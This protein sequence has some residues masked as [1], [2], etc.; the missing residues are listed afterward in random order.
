M[1]TSAFR[2]RR[3]TT[4]MR[5][6]HP[7]G[8]FLLLSCLVALFAGIVFVPGL[9]GAFVFDDIPNIVNN[10][11]V[12]LTRLDAEALHEVAFSPQLSGS[13]RVLPTLSFALDYWRGEGADAATFRIT[14]IV[15]HALTAFVLAWFFRSLLLA[16]GVSAERVRWAAP[17]L[18]LAWA[19]HP[20]HASSVL[21][22]VQRIQTMGTLFL[23][24]ALWTYL[25]A[26]K[27][28]IEGRSGRTGM[29]LTVMLWFAALGCKEDSVLL[30]AYT[31]ALELTVLR[32]GA[33]DLRLAKGLRRGYMFA[34]IA[35][36]AAY[37]FMVVPHFWHWD[38]YP[39]RNFSTLER[40]LTQ[41]R[42][43]CLYLSQIMLPAPQQMPFYYDWIQPSRGLL[44]PWTTLPA[45]VALVGLLGAAWRFRMRWPLFSLGVFL[46]F[47]AHFVASN[48]VGLELAFEHRNHFALVGAVLAIGSI[49]VYVSQR[50]RMPSGAATFTCITLLIALGGATAWRA[51]SWSGKLKLAHTSTELAPHS[52]RAWIALC[53]SYFQEGGGAKKENPYLSQAI[54]A[55]A[56]GAN[57][58][59]YALNS[60]ALLVVLKTLRGDVTQ[61]DW[62]RFQQ[63]L[64]TVSMSFDNR[65][66]PQILTHHALNG[67]E[68]DKQGLLKA[69]ST[70]VQRA[71][72]NP[73]EVASIGNFVMNDLSEPDQAMPYFIKAISAAP[74][75]DVYSQELAAELREKGRP[76]LARTIDKL[77]T[78]RL[79]APA[80]PVQTPNN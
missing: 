14:N 2:P 69:L 47:S 57:N 41:A 4:R 52:A 80:T 56:Q 51:H 15:I 17:V 13:M 25:V 53:S 11:A 64:E 37:L 26:R 20:L 30:P 76:D 46:F 27:A 3:L 9:P 65:R 43:L 36:A 35:G 45:I 61:Q 67:V 44:Q 74:P 34:A 59:P 16:S 21:Y 55:C 68:L 75:Y 8:R 7:H 31:L 77:V 72:L 38:A 63:R 19:A 79:A 54:D 22:V 78:S 71:P 42:V 50:I 1:R 10:K 48:V 49:L 39:G 18:A 24:L 62:D 28:Q 40:L 58:A 6:S 5:M 33:A 73:A 29:L 66:A 32:F 23:V 60:T 70:L 12:H